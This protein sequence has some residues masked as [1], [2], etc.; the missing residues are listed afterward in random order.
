MGRPGSG[1]QSTPVGG[2]SHT[3]TVAIKN[4]TGSPSD[5][6]AL[7]KQ[8]DWASLEHAFGPAEDTPAALAD[9]L[10]GAP[11]A[12]A[13][14]VA[15]LNDPVHH[16][17]SLYSATVPAA[18]YIAA[19]L[20]DPRTDTLMPG[21]EEG[22]WYPLRQALLDWLGSITDEVGNDA[23]ATLL[24]LGF[25]PEEYPAFTE[26]RA[27]RPMLFHTV[28]TFFQDA[29]PTVREAALAAAVPLLDAPELTH[30]QAGLA[31]LV[32]SVLATSSNR[33]YRAIAVDGLGA[34]G[35]E[36]ASLGGQADLGGAPWAAGRFGGDPPF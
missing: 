36:T 21:G 35:E 30:H 9:L 34:W 14:A 16:Q 8:T 12:R 10:I 19:I 25:S 32:H 3:A 33:V 27:I 23:E 4:V 18:L 2:A 31:P 6:L 13:K 29:N 15:H 11:E 28:S 17:N 22:Q 1:Q 24:R 7:I 26:L 5:P 20:S